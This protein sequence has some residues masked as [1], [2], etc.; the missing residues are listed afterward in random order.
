MY[1]ESHGLDAVPPGEQSSTGTDLF[2]IWAGA[3][4]CFPAFIIGALLVPAFSWIEAVFIILAGN[5][6]IG[7]LIVWGGYFGIRT[8][9]PAVVLGRQVFGDK[10]G[11]WVPTLGILLSMLGWSAVIT[12]MT[13]TALDAMIENFTGFS[14]PLL[15]IV[16]VG[17]LNASTAVTGYR[18]IR[19]LSWMTVPAM[20]IVCIL[21]GVKIMTMPDLD[22]SIHYSPDRV[23]SYGAGFNI[24]IGGSI[25]G[26]LV[27]S[28]FSRYTSSIRQNWW[29]ALSGTFLVS[30]LLGVLGMMAQAVTG[31]WN[32]LLMVQE[33]GMGTILFIFMLIA[34]WTSSDNL[35]YSSGLALS[36]LLPGLGRTRNTLI[37][38]ALAA[39]MAVA[40]ITSYLP[41]WLELL[42]ILLGPLLGVI[43][44]EFFLVK[45][46]TACQPLNIRALIALVIGVGAAVVTPASYIPS[47]SGLA[48]SALV[49]FT[50][51]QFPSR[52]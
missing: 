39:I 31:Q 5:F 1:I 48:V 15:F 47:L 36:N 26:A 20:V 28:D 23:M 42:S 12:A 50:L 45:V 44:S 18:N 11:Q 19:R 13:G 21:I 8:G 14:S 7:L 10:A 34:N 37:C 32:P 9:L 4:F 25:A 52:N 33:T 43:L 16:L 35:L 24:I 29:G 27:A 51:F 2:M 46:K 41:G 30:F 38:A 22:S 17:V 49:Y 3:S 40:G 6:I